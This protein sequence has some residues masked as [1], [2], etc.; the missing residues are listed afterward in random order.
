MASILKKGERFP[1]EPEDKRIKQQLIWDDMYN[2]VHHNIRKI[3]VGERGASEKKIDPIVPLAS[4][5]SDI[6]GDL[7]FGE[8]P[9]I[10]FGENNE[11]FTDTV[12]ERLKQWRTYMSDVLSAASYNSALGTMFWY[13]FK[14]N[15]KVFYKFIKPVNT[16]WDEDIIGLTYVMFFFEYDRDPNNRWIKFKTQEHYYDYDDSE[17]ESPLLDDKRKHIVAESIITV[18]LDDTRKI[19]KIEDEKTEESGLSFIPIIKVENIKNLNAKNGKSDYQGKEQ[20]LAEVDNRIDEINHVLTEHAE[21][22]TLL[23]PGVLN[24]DGNFN[25][26]NGK[27]IEKAQSGGQ[28]TNNVDVV[29]W[30]GQ[31]ESS[32][33]AIKMLIQLILFSS[34]ISNPIAGFFFDNTGG[35]VESGRALKWRSINTTSM[36]TKKR[37]TWNEAFNQFFTMWFNMDDQFKDVPDEI[38]M[39]VFWKDGLPLDEEAVVENVIKQV[40]ANVL[41]QQTAIQ[42]INEVDPDE[43]QKELDTIN[44]ELDTSA[45]RTAGTFRTEV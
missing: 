32:F 19:V 42:K 7:L 17:Y 40:R 2:N 13:L 45:N 30:D 12:H 5:I 6:N 36:I 44:D 22:W 18:R 4:L 41:S 24:E 21:P 1:S 28:G 31:L 9:N 26:S 34:R 3:I 27:M 14:M 29:Q 11:S 20:M 15:D 23:P 10:T 33:N 39:N 35:Q 37:N 8:F 38:D 16:I 43:A 25:R